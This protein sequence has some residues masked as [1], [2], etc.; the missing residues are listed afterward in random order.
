MRNILYNFISLNSL[1]RVGIKS[2][3]AKSN[4]LLFA[5]YSIFMTDIDATR[6]INHEHDP[7]LHANVPVGL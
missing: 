5:A 3:Q 4:Q 2:N 7:S 1:N 6:S